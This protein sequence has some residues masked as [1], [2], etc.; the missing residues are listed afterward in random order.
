MESEVFVQEPELLSR[1]HLA[2]SMVTSMSTVTSMSMSVSMGTS[3][4]PAPNN[5][6]THFLYHLFLPIFIEPVTDKITALIFDNDDL[7]NDMH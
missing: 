1:I 6:C 5:L 4:S 3:M 7:L 2:F